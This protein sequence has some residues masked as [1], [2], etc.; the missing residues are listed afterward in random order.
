MYKS[1]NVPVAVVPMYYRELGTFINNADGVDNFSC[2][3]FTAVKLNFHF[4]LQSKNKSQGY[5]GLKGTDINIAY[6]TQYSKNNTYTWFYNSFFI[7][8]PPKSTAPD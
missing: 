8:L 5:I 3:L 1:D 2:G 6:F 7:I 4:T